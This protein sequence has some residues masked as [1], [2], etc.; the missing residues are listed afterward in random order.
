MYITTVVDNNTTYITTVVVNN[1]TYITTVVVNNTTYI[2]TVV[3]N[4]T[5]A[6]H[7]ARI[8]KYTCLLSVGYILFRLTFK[9]MLRGKLTEI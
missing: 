8:H 4:N 9:D 7:V 2:T 6:H 5:L 1:T 3:V